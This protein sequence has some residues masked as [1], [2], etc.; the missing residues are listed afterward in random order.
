MHRYFLNQRSKLSKIVKAPS[1]SSSLV[2]KPRAT[3]A[4]E[5]FAQDNKAEI[6]QKMAEKRNSNGSSSTDG[7]NLVVYKAAREELWNATDPETQAEYEAKALSGKEK[8]KEG[9]TDDD[10]YKYVLCL[11]L[12][13]SF[14]IM[15]HYKN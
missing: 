6:I 1:A 13:F 3:P 9:P 12:F 7:G 10:I 2:K 14:N 8:I 5:L 15:I 11:T 4:V